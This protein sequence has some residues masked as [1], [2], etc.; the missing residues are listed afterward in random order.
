MIEDLKR[1]QIGK[2][3]ENPLMKNYTTYKVGGPALCMAFPKNIESLI[4]LIK[5]I[6]KN[7]LKYKVVGNGSNLIFK[8]EMYNGIIIKLNEFDKLEINNEIITVGAG[9]SL[10]KLAMKT[11]KLGLTG[12]EF[13][14]G[15]PGTVG[16]AIFMNAGA[17]NSDMGYVVKKVDV[18][19]PNLEIK[20]LYNKD[21][22]FHYRTSF[23][24]ENPD[25]ICLK[26]TI[27]LKKGNEK[28]ILE[29]LLMK[30]KLEGY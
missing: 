12:L 2:I 4:K 29:I 30:E 10:I 28:N 3:I 11:A 9:Y 1:L 15:I 6:K 5:Y 25:Y 16:G 20:T 14:T 22:N 19:T 27:A 8:D 21:L 26:V 23:L 17:Y 13:T 18:L 7:N 24:Q